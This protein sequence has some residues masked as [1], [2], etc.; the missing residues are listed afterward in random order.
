[1]KKN[2]IWESR[3]FTLIELLVVIAIIAILASMLLP[4]LGKARNRAK[5][6]KCTSNLK[7]LGLFTA[8]YSQEQ[9]DYIPL[10]H[11]PSQAWYTGYGYFGRWYI[12]LANSGNLD[13]FKARGPA[14]DL[15]PNITNSFLRCPGSLSGFEPFNASNT[16]YDSIQYAPPHTSLWA[17]FGNHSKVVTS[18]KVTKIRK[19]SE[20]VWLIDARRNVANIVI[21][22]YPGQPDPY[23]DGYNHR[24][25]SLRARHS[26][27][28]NHLFHDGHVRS[29]KAHE[30]LSNAFNAKLAPE[31]SLYTAY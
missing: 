15:T 23:L 25:F 3:F 7:Q 27:T 30:I 18:K 11:A 28:A 14:D 19:T 2:Q 29:L 13:K 26:G 21:F 10:N 17:G 5:K 9:E 12:K 4:A 20:A 8:S 16:V 31:T 6:I 24:T 1:M 22:H